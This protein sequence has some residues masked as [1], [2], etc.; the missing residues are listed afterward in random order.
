VLIRALHVVAA[1]LNSTVYV[2]HVPSLSSAVA[3]M[4]DSLT[5][6]STATA[7]VWA[8]TTGA[9]AH[10]A[11]A[12]LWRWLADPQDDWHLGFKLVDYL[13]EKK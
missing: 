8:Q 10:S 3:V 13:K 5:R 9:Q 2:H 4:A 12:P 11:P 1:F 7:K 6:S